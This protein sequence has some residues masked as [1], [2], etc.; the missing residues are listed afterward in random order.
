MKKLFNLTFKYS[1]YFFAFIGF[2]LTAGFFAVKFGITNEKGV[3]DLQKNTFLKIQGDNSHSI[4]SETNASQWKNTE[5]WKALKEAIVRDREAIY[6]A[7]A[8]FDV[9][10]RMIVAIIMVEQL[11]LFGDNRELFK[12][13]FAPLKILGVQSQFSWGVVGIKQET[14]IEVEKNLISTSSPFYPGEAYEALLSFST[15]NHDKE[16]F[17]RLTD[18][19]DRLY[20]YL[21]AAAIIKELETQWGNAGHSIT[22]RPD[23]IATLFNIGFKHSKPNNNP[24]SGGASIIVGEELYSFGGLAKDFYISEELI[25]YFPR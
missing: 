10:P 19:H 24:K 12:T 17:T 8:L 7:A 18:E 6:K 23:I 5:D 9:K 2:T 25:Q 1:I 20:S 14:A 4:S 22:K 21:Y 15:D 13:V 11:R 16:R 3:I